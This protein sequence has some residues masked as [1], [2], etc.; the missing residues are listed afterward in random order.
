MD[1]QYQL[2]ALYLTVCD[3]WKK[4]IQACVMRHSN[5]S[6]FALSDEEIATIYLFGILSGYSSVKDIYCYAKRHLHEWFPQL[7]GY[8]AF[9]YRLNKIDNGFVALCEELVLSRAKGPIHDWVIDSLP[10]IPIP[11]IN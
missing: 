2:I 10:I 3:A 7:R 8:E 11:L 6:S 4:R 5:N 9:N 1:W